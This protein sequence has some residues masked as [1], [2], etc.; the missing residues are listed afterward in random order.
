MFDRC[1]KCL[2]PVCVCLKCLSVRRWL[3]DFE[4]VACALNV[5]DAYQIVLVCS[6]ACGVV[7]VCMVVMFWAR[8]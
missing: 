8:V 4:S 2:L 6:N 1:A 3:R 5:V 7:G